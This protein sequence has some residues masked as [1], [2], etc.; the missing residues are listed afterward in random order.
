MH[1]SAKKFSRWMQRRKGATVLPF[2]NFKWL[3]MMLQNRAGTAE[4]EQRKHFPPQLQ[5]PAVLQH[6]SSCV[7]HKE[8]W[9][10]PTQGTAAHHSKA[11][12]GHSSQARL[13]LIILSL[14]HSLSVQQDQ[15]TALHIL[16]ALQQVRLHQRVMIWYCS[17]HRKQLSLEWCRSTMPF[18]EDN[19]FPQER[20]ESVCDWCWGIRTASRNYY[21]KILSENSIFR[22]VGAFSIPASISFFQFYTSH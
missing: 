20:K 13:F 12:S 9:R 16:L 14:S 21:Q 5:V 7:S 4:T 1:F 19:F 18:S 10:Q 8:L 22:S 17:M 3:G 6:S 11:S 15:P 2:P